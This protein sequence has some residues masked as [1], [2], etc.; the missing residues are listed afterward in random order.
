[1]AGNRQSTFRPWTGPST[2]KPGKIVYTYT[3]PLVEWFPSTGVPT[4]VVYPDPGGWT[5]PNKNRIRRRRRRENIVGLDYEH[6]PT[7]GHFR[8]HEG[9]HVRD[10][11]MGKFLSSLGYARPA[12]VRRMKK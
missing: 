9:P 6:H 4:L 12:N 5:K 3:Q 1:M 7:V 10:G 11:I 2:P 8:G